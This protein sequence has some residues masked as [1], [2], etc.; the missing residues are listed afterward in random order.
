M[1]PLIRT[2]F[3]L[4]VAGCAAAPS[5]SPPPGFPARVEAPEIRAREQWSYFLR[6]GDTGEPRGSVRYRV[7]AVEADG[8]TVVVQHDGRETI[9]RYTRDRNW[10][11]RPMTNRQHF[12]YEPAYAALPFPL[13]AGK[14]GRADVRA[15]DPATGR[16]HRVRIDG[17]VLGGERVRVPAGELDTLKVRRRVYAGNYDHFRGEEQIVEI[18]WYAPK[19]GRLVQ[20]MSSSV[21]IDTRIGCDFDGCTRWVRNDW[22]VLEV[23][24]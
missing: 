4:L 21:D 3:C 23:V 15:A 2:F 24:R 5:Q 1:K 20:Q 6:D 19:A 7:S 16:V 13:E 22:N 14:S 18:D 9:E 8:L 11:E 12:R 17:K 10:R